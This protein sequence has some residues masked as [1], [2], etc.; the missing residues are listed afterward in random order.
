M[1]IKKEDEEA[2]PSAPV[3]NSSRKEAEPK[4]QM[5]VTQ[6]PNA[7]KLE[8]M[9]W[10]IVSSTRPTGTIDKYYYSP[11]KAI[12]FRSLK[13][14]T[15]FMPIVEFFNGSEDKAFVYYK[16]NKLIFQ[17]NCTDK[18]HF[19]RNGEQ[20]NVTPRRSRTARHQVTNQSELDKTRKRIE[21]EV[22]ASSNKKQRRASDTVLSQVKQ[23]GSRVYA[24]YTNKQVILTSY[25]LSLALNG[26]LQISTL[27]FYCAVVLGEYYKNCKKKWHTALRGECCFHNSIRIKSC[28]LYFK[29]IILSAGCHLLSPPLQVKFDDEDVLDDIKDEH[30]VLEHEYCAE[31]ESAMPS[32]W[33]KLVETEPPDEKLN[34]WGWTRISSGLKKGTGLNDGYWYLSPKTQKKFRSKKKA[35]MFGLIVEYFNGSEEDA[36]EYVLQNDAF[37]N[38][39]VWGNPL[40]KESKVKNPID[41]QVAEACMDHEDVL[42]DIKDEHLVLEHEYCAEQESAMPSN[43]PKLVETEPPDEKLNQWGWTR[44]SSGLK[45][46]TGLNDGYWYLSPKTQKKFRSKKKAKMFG[47]IVEY[48]NGSEEDAYEY[49]LQNDAFF[50]SFV[51]RNPLKKESKVK[52]PIDVQV[53]EACMDST[54]NNKES[55]KPNMGSPTERYLLALRWTEKHRLGENGSIKICWSPP[56]SSNEFDS[57]AMAVKYL[58]LLKETDGDEE[59]AFKRLHKNE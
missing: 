54:N 37:F 1:Y 38:S 43:W 3:N 25:I 26:D 21:I 24:R 51:W 30:L 4:W 11:K 15:I 58:D 59:A 53:A 8:E 12:Q 35:K 22:G 13:Q 17:S 36:Y 55:D 6:E 18:K 34:Q 33:P 57:V 28:M 7:G 23:V 44:I 9:G 41:E 5:F 31:Q 40:K 46:G 39:F 48:F 45:K 16:K 29:N 42:D 50:N 2:D 56:E 47:L 27:Y 32:N 14:A 10:Q 52:N 20:E 19:N 49:V